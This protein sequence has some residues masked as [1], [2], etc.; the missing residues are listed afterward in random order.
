MLSPAP[1]FF[2]LQLAINILSGLEGQC[3]TALT[4][5][6]LVMTTSVVSLVQLKWSQEVGSVPP[7]LDKPILCGSIR[8][9]GLFTGA[10][11]LSLLLSRVQGIHCRPG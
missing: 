11:W 4:Q 3:V 8:P 9:A 1:C 2:L 5:H 10:P 6:N 7:P